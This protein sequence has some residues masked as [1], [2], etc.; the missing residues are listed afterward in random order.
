MRRV[1]APDG[2]SQ[3]YIPASD[4]YT[5]SV[6]HP[7]AMDNGSTPAAA[8]FLGFADGSPLGQ[9]DSISWFSNSELDL[10]WNSIDPQ[11]TSGYVVYLGEDANY[12]TATGYIMDAYTSPSGTG[13]PK[14]ARVPKSL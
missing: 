7:I 12:Q 6:E 9:P 10:T 3:Y 8:S 4:L 1:P 2:V 11:P 14:G 5:I 13:Y